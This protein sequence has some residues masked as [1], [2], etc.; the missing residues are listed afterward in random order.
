MSFVV[1]V[2]LVAKDLVLF[3]K[4]ATASKNIHRLILVYLENWRV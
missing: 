2:L 1:I 4:A 3:L